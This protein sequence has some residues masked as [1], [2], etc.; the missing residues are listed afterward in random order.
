MDQSITMKKPNTKRQ[1]PPT[2]LPLRPLITLHLAVI[3]L[4]T[5]AA[6]VDGRQLK[7]APER[8]LQMDA[9][10]VKLGFLGDRS[11]VV[12]KNLTAAAQ[13]CSELKNAIQCVQSYSRD[14]LSGF[15]RQLLTSLLKRGKQQHSFVC[16]DERAQL[17]MMRKMACITDAQ[18]GQL[19]ACMDGS[20]ARFDYI[21]S[22]KVSADNKLQSLCCSYHIFN[23]EVESTLDRICTKPVQRSGS[24]HEFVERV[25]SGTAGEFMGLICDQFRSMDECR[26]SRKTANQLAKMEEIT[27]LVNEGKLRSKNKSLVP[28][29]LE[30]LDSS[31]Q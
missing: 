28:V 12:P 5:L 23:R 20:V 16:H 6:T 7:C 19:H 3:L 1:A 21:N 27:K 13:F 18:I 4:L 2:T 17:N 10:A 9:C 29:L 22:N 25:V 14:C 31:A 11:F 8:E 26:N 15:T 30:I 24:T